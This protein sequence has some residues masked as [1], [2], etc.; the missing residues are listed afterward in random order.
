M[1]CLLRFMAVPTC[2][3]RPPSCDTVAPP[4]ELPDAAV[5]VP[6]AWVPGAPSNA[7]SISLAAGVA[8]GCAAAARCWPV[9]TGAREPAGIR[10]P[11]SAGLRPA[12]ALGGTTGARTGV[13]G[14]AGTLAAAS[15]RPAATGARPP[16]TTGARPPTTG[17]RPAPGYFLCI[18]QR[19]S[20][21]G[22]T[23]H[24]VRN[25]CRTFGRVQF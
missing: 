1:V 11:T 25:P 23:R 7:G 4:H 2:T 3:Q 16:P 5:P 18:F 21:H 20:G 22:K 6:P 17:E 19:Q 13:A 14:A 10:A 12:G 9:P 8:A 24:S 15:D